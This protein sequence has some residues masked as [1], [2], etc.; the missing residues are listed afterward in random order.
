MAPSGQAVKTA[1][2]VLLTSTILAKL[3]KTKKDL[4]GY[5]GDFKS[6]FDLAASA[7]AMPLYI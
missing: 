2:V 7:D 6:E 5:N 3:F 4:W 1:A